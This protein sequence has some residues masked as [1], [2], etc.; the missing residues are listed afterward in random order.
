[1]WLVALLHFL[2]YMTTP[3]FG[4]DLATLYWPAWTFTRTSVWHGQ[5]P[6]WNPYV[7]CGEPWHTNINACALFYPLNL[8]LYLFPLERMLTGYEW[9]LTALSGSMAMAL[10]EGFGFAPLA[11]MGGA[12]AWQ[13][14]GFAVGHEQHLPYVATMPWGPAW[15]ACQVRAQTS[16]GAARRRFMALGALCCALMILAGSPQLTVITG[17]LLLIWVDWKRPWPAMAIVALAGG[18]AAVQVVPS[19]AFQPHSTRLGGVSAAFNLSFGLTGGQLAGMVATEVYRVAGWPLAPSPDTAFYFGL[20]ETGLA[21]AG[22]VWLV[23][24]QRSLASRLVVTT[25]IG[26]LLALGA[27]TPL[28]AAALR[29]FPPLQLFR[30]PANFVLWPSLSLAALVAAGLEG[31]RPAAR[32]VLIALLAVD[33]LWLGLDPAGLTPGHYQVSPLAR[34]LRSS[35]GIFRVQFSPDDFGDVNAGEVV[36]GH[37]TAISNVTQYDALA[38]HD[39]VASLLFNELGAMP[40]REWFDRASFNSNAVYVSNTGTPLMRALNLQW[41]VVDG[42]LQPCPGSLPRFFVVGRQQVVGDL[43]DALRTL[44]RSDPGAVAL[45]DRP[46]PPVEVPTRSHILVLTYAVNELA[47]QVSTDRPCLLVASELYSPGWRADVDGTPAAIYR[48]DGI[49][50][51]VHV[52]AGTHEVRM[53]YVPVVFYAGAVASGFA[54]M[55]VGFLGFRRGQAG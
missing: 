9:F 6:L 7:G 3:P 28:Y 41:R 53:R 5:F 15:L 38:P 31:C 23:R 46:A 21:V 36:S 39:Y 24:R 10:F 20:L 13:L 17:L 42:H 47:V 11:A 50:R 48:A 1:M 22:L 40:D 45:V 14:C 32:G 54:L 8:P 27:Q 2:P 19:L 12:L 4:R 37:G 26:L 52:P 16:E 18:L 55:A 43:A 30:V 49:L 25:V 44:Q 29:V 34:S 51:A 35:G 33:L